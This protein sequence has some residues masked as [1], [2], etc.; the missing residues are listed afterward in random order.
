MLSP[1]WQDLNFLILSIFIKTIMNNM[2]VSNL[3]IEVEAL[4]LLFL[5]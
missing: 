2:T 4:I 5:T 1:I 3:K